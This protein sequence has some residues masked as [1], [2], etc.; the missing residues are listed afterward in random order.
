MRDK[1]VRR[2]M[3]R[4]GDNDWDIQIDVAY[5]MPLND[6]VMR[7]IGVPCSRSL[8]ELRARAGCA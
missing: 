4:N 3:K 2:F 6:S 1:A 8:G 5:R 7:S